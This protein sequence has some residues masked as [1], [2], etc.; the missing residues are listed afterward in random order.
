MSSMISYCNIQVSVWPHAGG[1]LNPSQNKL[2]LESEIDVLI[3]F[4]KHTSRCMYIY[5][6]KLK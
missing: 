6:T 1:G 2:T 5:T 3:T 4:L